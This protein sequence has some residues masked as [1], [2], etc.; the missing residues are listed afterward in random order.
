MGEDALSSGRG[1]S[2]GGASPYSDWA[3]DPTEPKSSGLGDEA[4]EFLDEGGNEGGD[5]GADEGANEGSID[6]LPGVWMV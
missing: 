3:R 1:A 6:P 4:R 5:E 2:E